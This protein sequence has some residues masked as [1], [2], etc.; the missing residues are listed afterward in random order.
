MRLKL[1]LRGRTLRLAVPI[2]GRSILALGVRCSLSWSRG[3]ADLVRPGVQ[4][5]AARVAR[6]GGTS[7]AR[8]LLHRGGTCVGQVRS[9]RNAPLHFSFARGP[10]LRCSTTAR[11]PCTIN[12]NGAG[13]R[14][15]AA[16]IGARGSLPVV[17]RISTVR[18]PRLVAWRNL[19]CTDRFVRTSMPSAGHNARHGLRVETSR[20]TF[21]ASPTMEPAMKPLAE[22]LEQRNQ[23]EATG[24]TA[25]PTQ[26]RL[27]LLCRVAPANRRRP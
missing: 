22:D 5:A 24:S 26:L 7:D 16:A 3:L 23:T 1:L 8:G 2:A 13:R 19:W 4:R 20:R 6:G 15:R 10:V 27:A 12:A 11:P 21:P 25:A 9:T 17:L 14:F 18:R